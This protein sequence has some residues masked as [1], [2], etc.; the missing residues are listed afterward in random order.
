MSETAKDN[1]KSRGSSNVL[2]WIALLMSLV[3]F[4]FNVL[5][6]EDNLRLI[7]RNYNFVI[8]LQADG[9]KRLAMMEDA[10]V[11]IVNAGNRAAVIETVSFWVA[12]RETY[13]NACES[14]NVDRASF[15]TDFKAAVLKEKD[16]LR[17]AVA[18][19]GGYY[20][21]WK[22]GKG[23]RVEPHEILMSDKPVALS[24][25]LNV[26]FSTPSWAGGSYV[27]ELGE[28]TIEPNQK[29]DTLHFIGPLEVM[30]LIHKYGVAF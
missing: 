5:R 8:R 20:L 24:L 7:L 25:C 16:V 30:P 19:T 27:S 10:S 11:T 28:L 29:G 17:Q 2:S 22:D 4:F 13:K 23:N 12:K 21:Y 1:I 6:T 14:P 18:I 3:T 15:S 26:Y 9:T